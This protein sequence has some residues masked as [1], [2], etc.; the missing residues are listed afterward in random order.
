MDAD[1]PLHERVVSQGEEAIGKLAQELLESSVVTGALSAAFETRE[2]AMRAQELALSAL[3]LPSAGDLGRITRRLR[4]VSQRLE[5]VEDG[6]DRLEQRT[7]R[8]DQLGESERGIPTVEVR[9]DALEA[10]LTRV[11]S[12]LATDKPLGSQP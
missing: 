3:N 9:L 10:A 12:A 1:K 6:L 8:L 5:A 11:E 7:D 4:N 2:R